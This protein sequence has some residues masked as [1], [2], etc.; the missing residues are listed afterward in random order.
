MCKIWIA[1]GL[2]I[3]IAGCSQKKELKLKQDVFKAELG[4]ALSTDLKD[5]LDTENITQDELEKMELVVDIPDQSKMVKDE[6]SFVK[7]G[8]YSAKI[9]YNKEELTFKIVIE[10][11][12][13][14][15]LD[16]PD[17]L[18]LTQGEELA[19]ENLLQQKI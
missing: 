17:Q 9:L 12:I 5:Y 15:E 11:T 19:T 4:T 10:D 2:I 7:T 3:A 13:K 8:E 1:I 6:L 14:P 18:E 16:G